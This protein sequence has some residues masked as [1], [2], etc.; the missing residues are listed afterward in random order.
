MIKPLKYYSKDGT[1][2]E[3]VNYTIDEYDGVIKNKKG[4]P[5]ACRKNRNGYNICSV[6]DDSG[7]QRTIRVARALASTFIGPPQTLEHTADHRNKNRCNDTIDNIRWIDQTGQKYNQDRSGTLKNAF[8]IVKD[9]M[10][11]TIKEWVEH[12]KNEKNHM[13][14]EYTVAMIRAYTQRKQF[15]FS[16]KTYPDL[17]EEMWK[18]VICSGNDQG[19]WQISNMNRVKYVTTH[20]ENVISGDR[21]GL[22][23]GYPNVFI[24]GKNCLCHILAFKTFFPIEWDAKKP[25]EMILHEDDDKMDFRPHK[26]RIGTRSENAIDA[27]NNGCHDGTKTTRIKF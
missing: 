26:L 4:K 16:Y 18:E 14:R 1:L 15:G 24:N 6:Y 27:H 9:G 2:V 23:N 21:L 5:L 20:A 8:L 13:M 3:F 25:D 22:N 10:E 11:K 19:H 12:L 7:K 17:P